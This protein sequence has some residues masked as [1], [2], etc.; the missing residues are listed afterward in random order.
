MTITRYRKKPIEVDTIQWTGGNEAELVEFTRHQFE[1]VPAEDRAE[2][3]DITA[4][5]FDELHSTWVGVY[6][7]HH[8]VRGVKGE[9]YPID[10]E[11]LA[12]TYEPIGQP[13]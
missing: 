12:E 1:A 10:P 9:Y 2:N 11:V 7:G 6:T 3:P 13:S 8:I 5:V 4:Q